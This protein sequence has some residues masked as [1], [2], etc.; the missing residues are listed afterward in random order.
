MN[1]VFT[2]IY[3]LFVLR[4]SSVGRDILGYEQAYSLTK[5]MRWENF[6]YIYF[7]KGYILLMKICLGLGCSFQVFLGIVYAIILIPIYL[8]IRK[9]SKNVLLSI[10]IYYCYIYFEFNLTG[11]RQSL[12]MSI[13]LVGYIVF[14]ES[15][16]FKVVK[17]LIFVTLAVFF[18]NGAVACYLFIL[19][20]P[21]KSIKKF[22]IVIAFGTI[23]SLIIRNYIFIFIKE[24][25][26]KDAFKLGA[27]LYFGGNIIFLLG[28]AILFLIIQSHQVRNGRIIK[29]NRNH[30]KIDSQ[31]YNVEEVNI[32]MFLISIMLALFFGSETSAR[33]YMFLNQVIILQLPNSINMLDA[34]SK[35]LSNV[36]FYVFFI[37]FF[38]TNTLLPNNFDIVPYKFF[39]Q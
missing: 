35:L 23:S 20:L 18:H 25:F 33:S 31:T 17:Y 10:I 12:A 15:K 29:T 30:L 19:L 5:N 34:K 22:T 14:V 3:L 36:F 13:V 26:D 16:N 28:L 7:E 11:I 24:F 6:S 38:F 4:S 39:W 27:G 1:I 2:A 32:K 21:I 37:I 8:V 9:Y